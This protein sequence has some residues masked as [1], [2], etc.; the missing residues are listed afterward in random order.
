MILVSRMY[1]CCQQAKLLAEIRK[2]C[3]AALQDGAGAKCSTLRAMGASPAGKKNTVRDVLRRLCKDINVPMSS[4]P[5]IVPQS[6]ALTGLV[7]D[8]TAG[9][10]PAHGLLAA[11]YAFDAAHSIFSSPWG[12]HQTGPHSGKHPRMRPGMLSMN[13]DHCCYRTRS[14]AFRTPN[15]TSGEGLLSRKFF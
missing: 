12:G 1:S 10:V 9:I 7:K 15:L 13:C 8:K 6:N 4:C 5:I 3:V 11:L 2:D 14:C